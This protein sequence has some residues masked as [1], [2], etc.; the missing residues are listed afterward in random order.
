MDILSKLV[1]SLS[2]CGFLT[3]HL[4]MP[5]TSCIDELPISHEGDSSRNKARWRGADEKREKR[6]HSGSGSAES[7]VD[8]DPET[9]KSGR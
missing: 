8:I 1:T 4:A 2:E 7:V 5:H 3:D 6:A 9:L